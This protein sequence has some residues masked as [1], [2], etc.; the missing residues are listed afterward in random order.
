MEES[1][2]VNSDFKDIANPIDNMEDINTESKKNT[3]PTEEVKE[4]LRSCINNDSKKDVKLTEE[5]KELLRIIYERKKDVNPTEEVMEFLSIIYERKK[6]VIPNDVRELLSILNDC[7]K[8]EIPTE[9]VKELLSVIYER[10]KHVI[11]P[12]DK[13]SLN[14]IY[15]RKKTSLT[16]FIEEYDDIMDKQKDVNPTGYV[17]GDLDF[18][19]RPRPRLRKTPSKSIWVAYLL[20][21]VGGWFGL[22][23]LYLRRDRQA[24][25][26]FTTIGG[27]L[28]C[29]LMRD[30]I[31]I[32][33]YVR[34]INASDDYIAE[35]T[36]K[37][38][39]HRKPPFSLI[40]FVSQIL[41]GNSWSILMIA[42]V[43]TE[44]VFG[45][46]W[47]S[48]TLLSPIGTAIGVWTI[49]NIGREQGQ[50]KWAMIGAY[51]VLPFSFFHPPL[52]NWSAISCALLFTSRGKEWRRTPYPDSPFCKRFMTLMMCVV[53]FNS[54]W[55]SALYFNATV[56]DSQGERIKLRDAAKN[57]LNSPMFLEFKENLK[58][59]FNDARENGW[60]NAWT[61]FVELLDPLGEGHAL[62]V[63]GLTSG[64]TQDEISSAYRKLA[65][66]WHP[67]RHSFE[68]KDEAHKRFMEIQEAY[69]KLSD[70]KN[71]RKRKNTKLQEQDVNSG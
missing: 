11:P 3:I 18:Q 14:T 45:L 43:P 42:A 57:F 55:G 15:K 17:A 53:V 13:E 51:I 62:K 68:N 50:L 12:V 65:K 2:S 66:E 31:R 56:T 27:Y 58:V 44:E 34:D 21:F 23:L 59:I 20:W 54:F 36:Q 52:A 61:N 10:K 39:K 41:V 70:I 7:K 29:G 40:R 69:E 28:G 47:T 60:T 32:P 1:E 22:H 46:S 26:L 49:G 25:I 9:E 48:L 30:F 19:K 63:L 4:L 6:D 33:A 37:M 24:F 16:D 71:R 64:A 5:A 38:K 67:D 8:D 35:L